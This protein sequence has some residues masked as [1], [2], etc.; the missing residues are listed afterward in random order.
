MEGYKRIDPSYPE[1]ILQM[2]E[3]HA[4]ADVFME[5]EAAKSVSR[6]QVF[7]F[8]LCI[9]GF[10]VAVLLAVMKLEAA[11]IT[12]AIGGVSPIIISAIVNNKK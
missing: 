7:S 4:E 3:K 8:I 1:R 9:I 5:K 2:A 6:G 12:A 10:G 11:A